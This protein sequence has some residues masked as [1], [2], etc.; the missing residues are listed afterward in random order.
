MTAL[1]ILGVAAMFLVMPYIWMYIA[2]WGAVQVVICPT[3]MGAGG[4]PISKDHNEFRAR[5]NRRG[6]IGAA[7]ITAIGSPIVLFLEWFS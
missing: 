2:A 3:M 6:T 1:M 7:W 4:G 5:F